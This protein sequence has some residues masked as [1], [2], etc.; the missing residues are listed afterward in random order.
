MLGR[1]V[2]GTE[3]MLTAIPRERG[4]RGP[5]WDRRR[6][7]PS[8]KRR[9]RS[10]ISVRRGWPAGRPTMASAVSGESREDSVRQWGRRGSRRAGVCESVMR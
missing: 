3:R 6:V 1:A 10:E 8:A 4:R 7:G 5:W 9:L 2:E